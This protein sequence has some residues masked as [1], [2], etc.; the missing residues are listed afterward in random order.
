MPTDGGKRRN[1]ARAYRK[2]ERDGRVGST[3]ESA[4]SPKPRTGIAEL[5]GGSRPGLGRGNSHKHRAMT[6]RGGVSEERQLA[7]H[8]VGTIDRSLK[9]V[10]CLG[11]V[12]PEAFYSK[13]MGS[14]S[15]IKFKLLFHSSFKIF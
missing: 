13:S 1:D 6:H 10:F 4:D 5:N 3:W 14:K 7:V 12:L 9:R 15:Q 11:V 8:Q 2:A